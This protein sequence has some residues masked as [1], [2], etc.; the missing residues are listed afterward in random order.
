MNPVEITKIEKLIPIY[1]EGVEAERI[2]VARVTNCEFNIIVGK[3]LY[4]VGDDVVY[5]TPD[6]CLPTSMLFLDYHCPGGDPKKSRLGKKGRLRALKFNFQFKGESNPIY[7]N[8][9]VLPLKEVQ[10]FL[11]LERL[12]QNP[13]ETFV[14]YQEDLSNLQE[15]LN[16]VKY[17]A[18]DSLESR[19]GSSGKSKGVLPYF[20]YSTDEPR[21]ESLKSH[22]NKVFEEQEEL[23]LTVKKDGSSLTNY[24]IILE[25]QET[26]GVCS[27][28]L[29][30]QLEQRQVVGYI[31]PENGV[32]LSQYYNKDIEIK[33]WK[34]EFTQKFYT[35]EEVEG[36]EK[37][38][39]EISDAWVDTSKKLNT[40][41]KLSSYCRKYNTQLALR[42][43]LIGQGNK[44]SGNKLNW[45]SKNDSR[46][47]WFGIDGLTSGHATRIN[48][49]QEHNL[50]KVCEELE[51]EYTKEIHSDIMDYDSIIKWCNGYFEKT[52]KE[53]GQVIEGIVI[54]SKY[55]NK[56]S[57]KYINPE[58]DS[59][60]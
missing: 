23:S 24:F 35:N 43:E 14:D 37:V 60:S 25:G 32:I 41:E 6:Y 34:N 40:L 5:I 53:T 47:V 36:F 49:S 44:G 19:G 45:D 42:G 39:K 15:S 52:K 33:G 9:V 38:E 58:Y 18:E 51:M 29:E 50:K 27:R 30:K 3:G 4:K 11:Y 55:S 54:R 59:F 57:C 8:G 46:I 20:L 22:I 2:E 26:L 28:N 10:N 21:I 13:E 16:I 1:K 7:S 17:T 48:Y 31:D 56:L 12:R